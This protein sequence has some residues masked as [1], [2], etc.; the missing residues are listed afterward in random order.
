MKSDF[1]SAIFIDGPNL[2]FALRSLKIKLDYSQ[3]AK[4]LLARYA[5]VRKAIFYID[6]AVKVNGDTLGDMN[7]EGF[8]IRAPV[9]NANPAKAM[10]RFDVQMAVDMVTIAGAFNRVIL[11]SGDSDLL[12][13]VIA[14][15]ERNIFVEIMAF[16]MMMAA[17][18]RKAASSVVDLTE[19]LP[20][21]TTRSLVPKQML[22]M[23]LWSLKGVPPQNRKDATAV[24][25]GALLERHL[26]QLCTANRLL[27]EEKDGLDS[28]NNR[29][30]RAG[31]YEKLTQKKI[32]VW[33]EIRN[34][35]VHGHFEKYSEQDV[36]DMERWIVKFTDNEELDLDKKGVEWKNTT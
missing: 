35:A 7:R 30:A 20:D 3:F 27:V 36:R 1:V 23:E 28:L 33:A 15:T 19:I 10:Q 4:H 29:L 12:P 9:G 14:L 25:N 13:S 2:V 21:M 18:L 24:W 22:Q 6:A 17:D 26:R 32:T 8:E 11:I 5:P 16:P 31:V 34:K